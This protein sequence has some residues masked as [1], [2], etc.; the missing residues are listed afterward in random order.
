MGYLEHNVEE[1]NKAKEL[2]EKIEKTK[3]NKKK[4]KVF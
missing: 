4:R 2:A 1:H 3:D